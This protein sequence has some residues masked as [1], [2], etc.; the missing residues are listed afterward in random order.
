MAKYFSQYLIF[1]YPQELHDLNFSP[2][3]IRIEKSRMIKWESNVTNIGTKRNGYST[4]MGN[5]EDKPARK[6]ST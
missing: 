5:T 4:L 3:V 6:I 1:K 2:N